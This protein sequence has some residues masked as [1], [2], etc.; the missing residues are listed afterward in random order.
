MLDPGN[1][2]DQALFLLSLERQTWQ[3]CRLQIAA[4]DCSAALQKISS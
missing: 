1:W 4:L 2:Q 3:Q